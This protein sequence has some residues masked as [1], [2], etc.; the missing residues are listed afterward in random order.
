MMRL[1]P[2]APM[3]VSLL[4]LVLAISGGA[5]AAEGGSRGTITGC[6]HH[7][8]GGLYIA[9]KCAR[10][11][12]RLSWSVHGPS[13]ATGATG[14]QGP[15]GPATGAAGGDLTGSYPDPRITAGAVTSSDFAA[16]AVAPDST[17]LGG[18]PASDFGA[19]MSGRVNGLGT[20]SETLDYGAP[21]G[22]STANATE[23]NVDTL[24]PDLPLVARDLSVQLT[25]VTGWCR[26][27]LHP[28][29]RW[30]R[31]RAEVLDHQH[32]DVHGQ[33]P[34]RRPGR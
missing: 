1:R 12:R 3:G 7:R 14:R 21:S 26:A 17:Q 19:V 30:Q 22:T 10:H 8:G 25:G 33:R 4:A 23:S 32:L 9:R 2:A 13:G 28:G 11:D 27:R 31:D 6:V 24:S 34:G 29:G 20:S 18:A 16:G 5:I 15:P